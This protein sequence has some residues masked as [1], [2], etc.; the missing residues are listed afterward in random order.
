VNEALWASSSPEALRRFVSPS[1]DGRRQV[2]LEG[3][4]SRRPAPTAAARG[5]ATVEWRHDGP[6]EIGLTVASQQPGW[7]VLLDGWDKG[8]KA[9]VNG[10]ATEV[11]RADYNFRAVAVPAGTSTVDFSYRPTS[12][13]VGGW[14]TV[15]ST[16]LIGCAVVSEWARGRP[17]RRARWRLSATGGERPAGLLLPRKGTP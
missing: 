17:A 15:L 5:P 2:V 11:M 8:W 6:D 1:F 10:R 3:D 12:V 14:V 16:G 13:T 4:P 7:L 9:T